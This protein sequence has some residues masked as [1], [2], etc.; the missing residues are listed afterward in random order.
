M[1]FDG[2]GGEY[3]AAGNFRIGQLQIN[4]DGNLFFPVCLRCFSTARSTD[5]EK[6]VENSSWVLSEAVDY[7][8]E[9]WA[10]AA[11][12]SASAAVTR[13]LIDGCSAAASE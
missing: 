13:A 3:Q 5:F 7:G 1:G 12:R 4:K 11:R 6:G 9:V 2:V 10:R 8:G